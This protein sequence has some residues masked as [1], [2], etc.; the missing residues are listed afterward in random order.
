MIFMFSPPN[1]EE[2]TV[3][4]EATFRIA[5]LLLLSIVY[6]EIYTRANYTGPEFNSNELNL[7]SLPES[8]SQN[9]DVFMGLECDGSYP[10]KSVVVPHT[11]LVARVLLGAIADCSAGLWALGITLDEDGKVSRRL[12]DDF[13]TTCLSSHTA[14]DHASLRTECIACALSM[15]AKDT[16]RVDMWRRLRSLNTLPSRFW[17]SGRAAVLHGRLLIDGRYDQV[18]TLWQEATDDLLCAIF[19]YDAPF[20]STLIECTDKDKGKCEDMDTSIPGT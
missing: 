13:C 12:A 9:E 4:F 2:Q 19:F 7:L 6:L 20:R 11:L 17:W 3:G 18:P 16:F 1:C 15:E 10:Y 14:P 5:T 8:E